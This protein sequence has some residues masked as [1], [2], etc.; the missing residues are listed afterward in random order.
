M[1]DQFNILIVDDE[2]S[3]CEALAMVLRTEGYRVTLCTRPTEVVGLLR[4][5]PFDLVISDLIMPGMDG[6]TLLK[7]VKSHW[8]DMRFIITTA[9]GTI[10]NAVEAM[11]RGALTYIIK[12][13]AP[14]KLLREVERV[15]KLK[16]PDAE[17]EGGD[18]D[19]LSED[20]LL[21]TKNPEYRE[22]LQMAEKAAKSDA[23]LLILGESGVGKEVLARYIHSRSKRA[24][25]RFLPTNCHTF[26]ENLLESELFGHEKGAFT[27]AIAAREGRFEAA[28]DGT[29]FLDEIGDVPLATQAKL[30][31]ALEDKRITR[32]G[33]NAEIDVDFRLI[34][35]TNKAPGDEIARGSFREDLFY[36]ISTIMLYVPPLR[37]RKEDIPA[38]A[39]LFFTKA[40]QSVGLNRLSVDDAVTEALLSYHYPGNIRELKNIIERLVVLS[41]DGKVRLGDLNRQLPEN[42]RG[43]SDGLFDRQYSLKELRAEVESK[44]I[45]RLLRKTGGNM[46]ETA[47]CLGISP[48]HLSNKL[49][50]YGLRTADEKGN[51]DHER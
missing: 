29:L 4:S 46:A 42:S 28:R 31:R 19:A 18:P 17:K 41:D 38:L 39:E 10:E 1:N 49:A 48:R 16:A 27:G 34:S 43:K 7:T 32:I 8:P 50:A 14:E 23:N 45:G 51:P 35:A 21:S 47:R 33:S 13:S 36:R 25:C 20:F 2:E 6:V 30:L 5:E 11:R 24:R 3:Y 40:R 26:A 44:Y 12:G 9:Y 15:K 22:A 37:E